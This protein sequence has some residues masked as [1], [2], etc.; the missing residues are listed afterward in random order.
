MYNTTY[1]LKFIYGIARRKLR[2]IVVYTTNRCNSRC[3]TCFIW[4]KQPKT[5]ILTKTISKILKD[6][7]SKGTTLKITG[8][9]F[10]LHPEYKE[11]LTLINE[12]GLKYQ[13]FSNGILVERLIQTVRKFKVREVALSCD[14]LR[15]KYSEIRSVDGFENIVRII[16]ELRG[17]T[18]ITLNYTI[19][20]LN[21]KSDLRQVADFADASKVKLAVG[22]FNRPEYFGVKM[23]RNKAYNLDGI[24]GKCLQVRRRFLNK[25]IELYNR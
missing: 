5:D 10:L 19:S 13:L 4:K 16:N 25:Y 7:T 8:G 15:G 21:S 12:S 6:E 9:E 2:N 23:A 3:R 18:D 22:I 24:T 14:G 17:G 20:P 1:A 11:I